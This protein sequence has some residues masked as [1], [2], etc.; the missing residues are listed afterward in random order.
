MKKELLEGIFKELEHMDPDYRKKVARPLLSLG[1]CRF[2][3]L[4]RMTMVFLLRNGPQ[5]MNAIAGFHGISKQ[6]MTPLVEGLEKLG[7][8]K[9]EINPKNRRE[10]IVSVTSEGKK[11]F[12]DMKE[13]AMKQWMSKLDRFSDDDIKEIIV[14][15]HA[16][17][18]FLK[19]L[20]EDK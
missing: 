13:E 14:H 10:I 4:Q 12:K 1:P 15:L 9:R 18:G 5:P 16:I 19:R 7:M 20:D 17:N 3:G 6:Q 11:A 8:V 2:T